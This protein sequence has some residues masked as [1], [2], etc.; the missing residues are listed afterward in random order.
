MNS[1]QNHSP[2]LN[3]ER[4]QWNSLISDLACDVAIVGAGISGVA[5][6]Y[7]LLTSTEKN[8]VLLE[9]NRVASGATGHNAGLAVVAM[10]KPTS[11]LI[12]EIGEDAAHRLYEEWYEAWDNLH[13]IHEEIG[14]KDNLLSFSHAANGFQTLPPFI[15]FV[16]N[17][18]LRGDQQKWRFLVSDTLKS[19]I[20]QELAT[21]VEFIPHPALLNALKTTDSA[22][23][24][25]NVAAAGFKGKRMNSALF[26]YKVLRFL[27]A[28][29]PHRFKLYE[30]T[31]ITKID[32]YKN[33]SILVHAQGK[34]KADDVILC[35]NAYKN[36]LIW[37]QVDQK[38]FTKLHDAISPRI[39]YLAAFPDSPLVG[40]A[41]GLINEQKPLDSVPFWYFSHAP[42]PQHDP[43]HSCVI[44]GPEFDANTSCTQEWI[45]DKKTLSLDLIQQFLKSTF[46]EMP[47]E[48]PFFWHGWMGY[49]PNGLRWVGRDSDHPHLWYNLACNGIGI[50]PAIAGAKKI[51]GSMV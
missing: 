22:Y 45:D 18:L 37:D 28:K 24:A 2:W 1:S 5:T 10:E 14:L 8:V 3:F 44:G 47:T 19:K 50:I 46:K 40:Y 12:D 32:L 6:L 35:T 30:E 49:T 11:E 20:P 21:I 23:I 38:A 51:L 7:Y 41:L 26:C 33:H 31:D 34:I 42:H 9:K 25:A 48:F 4:P 16:K 15:A 43:N 36:F 29:F 39:G 13:A 27:Q 17:I